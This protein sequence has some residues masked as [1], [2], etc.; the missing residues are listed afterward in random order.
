MFRQKGRHQRQQQMVSER[1]V[2]VHPHP[3]TRGGMG[4]GAAFGLV[5]IGQDPHATFV[6][7]A[8]LGMAA[9]GNPHADFPLGCPPDQLDRAG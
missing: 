6:E 2:G 4:A 1:H 3:A 7:R 5:Q 8:T 9:A